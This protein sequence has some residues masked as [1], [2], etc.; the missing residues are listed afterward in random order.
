MR[1]FAS[2][3]RSNGAIFC[4]DDRPE[5]EPMLDFDLVV[6]E[7]KLSPTA[8]FS[9]ASGFL[10]LLNDNLLKNDFGFFPAAA[11]VT[12]YFEDEFDV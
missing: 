1:A 6:F 11:L 5:A 7:S 4:L 12:F 9:L 8:N 3:L 2:D 10:A